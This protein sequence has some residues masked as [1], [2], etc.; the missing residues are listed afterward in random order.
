MVN[1]HRPWATATSKTGRGEGRTRLGDSVTGPSWP[2]RHRDTCPSHP[3]AASSPL[4][5]SMWT[6]NRLVSEP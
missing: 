5:S 4:P 6:A 3:A 2:R 1:S